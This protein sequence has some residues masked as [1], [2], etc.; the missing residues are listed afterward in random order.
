MI[1]FHC[2][3]P[4]NLK[5]I[6]DEGLHD[7]APHDW[8]VSEW[9]PMGGIYFATTPRHAERRS[10]GK[11]LLVVCEIDPEAILADEDEIAWLLH[12]SLISACVDLGV[13]LVDEDDGFGRSVRYPDPDSIKS[14]IAR[15]RRQVVAAF[16]NRFR[17]LLAR[18]SARPSDPAVIHE[19]ADSRLAFLEIFK[20]MGGRYSGIGDVPPTDPALARYRRA[21][22]RACHLHSDVGMKRKTASFR[23]KGDIGYDGASR[24]LCIL[25]RTGAEW[26]AVH[27]EPPPQVT[28]VFGIRIVADETGA[29][30]R[31]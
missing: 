6:L 29:A 15:D 16:S 10:S 26:I 5:S 8:R 24:I 11:G 14:E 9:Q 23:V 12:R 31:P 30:P 19:L 22:D 7:R 20:H 18:E 1:A 2:T 4:N 17:R 25:R 3:S 27:G 13:P 21:E 28:E